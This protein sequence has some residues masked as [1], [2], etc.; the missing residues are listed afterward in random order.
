MQKQAIDPVERCN[1][2]HSD[3]RDHDVDEPN[4]HGE[5]IIEQLQWTVGQAD[6][7]ERLVDDAAPPK[8][9]SPCDRTYDVA[10]KERY[11]KNDVENDSD[12]SRRHEGYIVCQWISDEC[13][14]SGRY[15]PNP[16]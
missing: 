11:Q 7:F 3:E 1:E 15:Q 12:S 6:E 2:G 13:G 5:V 9:D 14:Y 8:D 16:D 4:D 10:G